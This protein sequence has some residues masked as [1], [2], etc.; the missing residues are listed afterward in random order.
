MIEINAQLKE[1]SSYKPPKEGR[2]QYLR[3]DFNENLIGC[4]PTVIERLRNITHEELSIYPEYIGIYE[5]LAQRYA[6]QDDQLL[7]VSGSDE[8]LRLIAETYLNNNERILIPEPSFSMFTYYGS[9]VGAQCVKYQLKDDFS[10]PTED[11]LARLCTFFKAVF[12]CS[13]NNPT[14]TTITQIDLVRILECAPNTLVVL[15]EAYVDF[16]SQDFLGLINTYPNLLILRTFSKAYGLA[17]LRIGCIYANAHRIQELSKVSSPF[18]VNRVAVAALEAAIGDTTYLNSYITS[19]KDNRKLLEEGLHNLEFKT[20]ESEANFILVE[21]GVLNQYLVRGLRERGILIRDR[22]ADP[23]LEG[24]CRITVGTADQVQVL[25][26]EI[27]TLLESTTVIF[28][29]DGVLVEVSQ[30]YRQAIIQ[31]VE[32][33]TGAVISSSDIDK[34]KKQPNSNNDWEVTRRI[35]A[36]LGVEKDLSA[37]IPIFQ[38]FYLGQNYDGLIQNE[39]PLVD[40]ADLDRF[41]SKYRMAIV[42]GRPRK[43]AE[44]TLQKFGFDKYFDMLVTMDE[45]PDKPDPAG[46]NLVLSRLRATDALYIGDTINDILA[47]LNANVIP[48]GFA[49]DEN[50]GYLLEKGAI[51]VIDRLDQLGGIL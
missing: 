13:P 39:T 45:V 27:K 38:S 29:M 37:I 9:V 34:A 42:T 44:F 26:G 19:I 31:T 2:A 51:Q 11:I 47:A 20:I 15:D 46:I 17:G 48:I 5:K 12:I 10:F 8:G 28:D 35:M 7:L 30:S 32:Y 23:I 18:A 22:S 21:F 36:I 25:L 1:I 6:I 43:E 33:F 14:G 4:S 40:V 50:R 3:L 49:K 24:Y 41:S 16:S